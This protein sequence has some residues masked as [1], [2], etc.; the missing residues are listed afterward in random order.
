MSDQHDTSLNQTEPQQ[1]PP[2]WLTSPEPLPAV[3]LEVITFFLDCSPDALVLVN[4][5]GTL[6]LVNTHLER[7]FGYSREELA[8]Q[9]LNVL[10]PEPFHAGQKA[11]SQRDPCPR[12]A[13]VERP[14]D[15][16][17]VV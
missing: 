14:L 1:A 4:A 7:L 15:R 12:A 6:V 10:L 2:V 13:G 3:M 17:S 5:A 11:Q 8:G 9:P 16:K